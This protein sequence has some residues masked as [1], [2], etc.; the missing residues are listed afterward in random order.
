M[1]TLTFNFWYDGAYNLSFGTNDRSKFDVLELTN[2]RSMVFTKDYNTSFSFQM[3][4]N[5]IAA[6][7]FFLQGT[8]VV[9]NEEGYN[10]NYKPLPLDKMFCLFYRPIRSNSFSTYTN[11]FMTYK[12]DGEVK[13]TQV[14]NGDF[15]VDIDP[16]FPSAQTPKLSSNR[17]N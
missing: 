9:E 15:T 6:E 8:F 14:R 17:L 2:D 7:M 1:E 13:S 16:L 3:S 5:T 11:A 10:L 12:K 4:A